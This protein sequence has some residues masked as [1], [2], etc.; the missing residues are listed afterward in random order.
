MNRVI[1]K[2]S[3][4]KE[5]TSLLHEIK[6]KFK[7]SQLKAAISV[8][9]ELIKF[10][11]YVG[12]III[13]KQEKSSW[14]DKLYETLAKDLGNSFPGTKGFSKTNLKNMKMFAAYYKEEEISQAL[15]DQL[16]WTHHIVLL[17]SKKA[18]SFKLKQWY[19][20]QAVKNGWSYRELKQNI[21]SNLYARQG[22]KDIKTT[23]F[24]IQLSSAR[25]LLAQEL[26]KDPYKFHFLA[27]GEDARE[28]DIHQ[29]LL[30]HVREFLM[31]LGQ[32][33]ALYGSNYPI[34]VSNKR[35]EIDLL[36]YN[37]RLHSYVVIELKKGE[38]KP[39]YIGQLNFYLTSV[40]E[41]LK[42]PKDNSSIGLLLCEEK[43]RVI[44]EYSLK[45]TNSPISI[46]EYQI[47]R[48]IPSK[49]H[50]ILPTIEEIEEELSKDIGQEFNNNKLNKN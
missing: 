29:G 6:R 47:A 20:I 33:F 41:Q 45:G 18:D 38:F 43:D 22:S 5:Y 34:K 24:G 49:L 32:G 30:K 28:K 17:Q 2:L 10:Y 36:M 25:S 12:N 9:T 15:P 23:N 50:N 13:Q 46:S 14:G 40:D 27:M 8:N 19:A 21:E 4:D 26:V 31:E 42:S 16:S 48:S 39:E 7:E 37:T 35:Y 11:W 44:A 1:K 3:S